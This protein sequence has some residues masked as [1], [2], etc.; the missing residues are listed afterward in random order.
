MK[1]KINVVKISENEVS[2]AGIDS[3]KTKLSHTR[4]NMDGVCHK[5]GQAGDEKEQSVK[6]HQEVD[7]DTGKI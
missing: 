5:K 2:K 1:L 4:T 3:I 6:E 7:T